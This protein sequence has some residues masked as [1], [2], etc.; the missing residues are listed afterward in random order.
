MGKRFECQAVSFRE[1]A[2]IWGC[3]FCKGFSL[4]LRFLGRK[5]KFGGMIVLGSVILGEKVSLD[6]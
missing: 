2:R 4:G 3:E 6:L 1:K 5:L